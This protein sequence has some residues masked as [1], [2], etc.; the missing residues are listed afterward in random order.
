M[1]PSHLLAL[2]FVCA[3]PSFAL[4]QWQWLDQSGRKVFSDQPPPADVPPSRILRQP[5]G[6]VV[7]PVAV[8]PDAAA[9]PTAAATS[10]PKL[11]GKDQA[12]EEKKKQL[13]SAEA[14]KKKEDEEKRAVAR[15]DSCN[16]A[17]QAKATFDSGVRIARTNTKGE[18]E[19]LDDKERA[20][21]A[22][23]AEDTVARDCSPAAQ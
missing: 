19:F 7:V 18:K 14:A 23:R 9:K 8:E 3:M 12:L 17:R 16:R 2:A 1:K 5:G 4:A 6:R 21:E 15:Q 13:E 20:A 11:S 22:K 10:A